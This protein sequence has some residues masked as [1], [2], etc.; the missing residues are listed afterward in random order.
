MLS[1]CVRKAMTWGSR[2][3]ARATGFRCFSPA[4]SISGARRFLS[5]EKFNNIYRHSL[6]SNLS[7]SR[8][9]AAK[10]MP[11]KPHNA[12]SR[13]P[14]NARLQAAEQTGRPSCFVGAWCISRQNQRCC[15]MRWKALRNIVGIPSTRHRWNGWSFRLKHFNFCYFCSYNLR[16]A[17]YWNSA[18]VRFG[19]RCCSGMCFLVATS[20]SKETCP[21]IVRSSIAVWSSFRRVLFL[22]GNSVKDINVVVV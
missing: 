21:D 6:E 8:Q 12:I 1:A 15:G 3:Q 16:L 5:S 4:R 9:R 11:G 13:L 20:A 18:K 17:F 19:L 2:G 22:I 7:G 14:S 10:T